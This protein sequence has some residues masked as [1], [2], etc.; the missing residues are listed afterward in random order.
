MNDFVLHRPSS[1]AEAA[2]LLATPGARALAGGTDLVVSLRHGLEQPALLVDLCA[3]PGLSELRWT[4]AGCDIGACCTLARLAGDA[5]LRGAFPALAQAA[6]SVAAPTHRS[7]AT[8]GGNLCLDTRCV[9]YNQGEDW[10]RSSGYCLKRGGDTCHVAP[11]GKRC[12]AAFSG[13][14]APA[15][16]ALDAIIELVSPSGM[17]SVPLAELYRDDGASHLAL[18]PGEFIAS[19]RVPRSPQGVCSAYRKV[20]TRGAIDFPLAGIAVALSVESGLIRHLRVSMTGTNPRPVLLE[21]T[22][23]LVGHAVN[24]ASLARIG[25]LVQKQASPVRTTLTEA[26]YRRQVA[27]VTAQRLVKELAAA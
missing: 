26:N 10:R 11:R 20:R 12:H 16:L 4:D 3:L 22:N 8:L 27:A 21:G 9:Y 6:L 14:V 24:E 13:D 17:R 2:G 15:L 23:D 1:L 7:A 19:V 18:A 25:K 5:R